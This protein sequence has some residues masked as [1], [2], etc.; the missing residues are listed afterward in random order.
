[1]LQSHRTLL[2][3]AL[4]ISQL[5]NIW[6]SESLNIIQSS[7]DDQLKC[8]KDRPS[9]LFFFTLGTSFPRAQ[10]LSRVV[11]TERGGE[12]NGV[13]SLHSDKETLKN[14]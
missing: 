14:K 10:K 1:M 6:H 5:S 3:I 8:E 11:V 12:A 13:E 9:S 7:D 4:N 2:G